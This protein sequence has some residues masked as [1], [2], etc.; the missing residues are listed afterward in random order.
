MFTGGVPLRHRGLTLSLKV[1]SGIE[2]LVIINLKNKLLEYYK[3]VLARAW[4]FA[5]SND[6]THWKWKT[7]FA[8]I[9]CVSVRVH[10]R[11]RVGVCVCKCI[12]I[13]QG[14][15]IFRERQ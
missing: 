6:L 15:T 4:A 7:G 5:Y 12:Y 2:R 9:L 14:Y 10:V 3:Q 11:V 8:N 1:I 13:S